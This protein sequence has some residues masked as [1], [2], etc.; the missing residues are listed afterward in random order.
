M[1][2]FLSSL[3]HRS[4]WRTGLLLLVHLTLLNGS[5]PP[6]QADKPTL[7]V[8]DFEG[9]GISE[10]E[11]ATLTHRFRANLAQIGP[12]TLIERGVMEEIL[13]EQ[14]FQETGCTT[15][16]CAVKIGQL[17]GAQFILAG[18]IGK[19]GSTWTV[20]MRII[21]VETGAIEKTAF[22]DTQGAIDLMLTEGME[23]AAKRIMNVEVVTTAAQ[24]PA[25]GEMA[26]KLTAPDAE[27]GDLFGSSVAL[28]GDYAIVGARNEDAMGLHAGAAYVFRHTGTNSWDNGTKLT[29]PDGQ[30]YDLFGSSVAL[31]D[32]YAIVGAWNE[33]AMGDDAGAA[34]VF[35]RTG[36]NSWSNGT[37]LT[38][39]DAEASDLFSRS[40]ALSG[41]YAIV[42]AWFVDAMSNNAGAAY[43]FRRTGTNSWD[44]G[45][46]LTAPDGQTSDELGDSV[47]LSG[48]YAIA[49]ARNEDAMGYLAGA[50]YVF[51]V[52]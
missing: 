20:E 37:K 13:Q 28:S 29:A 43:V 5:V 1:K 6:A 32:D 34:Y 7:A 16:E 4:P 11:V 3:C 38:A 44:T 30:A 10:S 33:D 42:G 12:Y 8:L 25:A 22:Y 31:S 36:T 35:R 23:V 15:D 27:A 41:D 48:R 51:R 17:L 45:V 49:G 2:P 24:A 40:V 26:R 46:K 52:K 18:S 47:S 14:G 39:P 50:A 9:F 21:N 19:V